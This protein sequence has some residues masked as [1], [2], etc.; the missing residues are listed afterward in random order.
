VTQIL[1]LV[2]TTL[3]T[4]LTICVVYIWWS[5][6]LT[7]STGYY[8]ICHG[9]RS[10]ESA[11]RMIYSLNQ[12]NFV[13]LSSIYSINTR[14]FSIK[15]RPK[16]DD[17]CKIQ[18]FRLIFRKRSSVDLEKSILS[19]VTIFTLQHIK[20]VEYSRLTKHHQLFYLMI[21]PL[22]RE[23]KINIINRYNL[24]FTCIFYLVKTT[25]NNCVKNLWNLHLKEFKKW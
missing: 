22:V 4:V 13:C 7:K 19:M 5:L 3:I 23:N 24:L 12:Q 8:L 1:Y 17:P 11:R 6:K 20:Y 14:P 16:M 9:Q 18:S 15:Q 21:S 25:Q 2:E 10:A